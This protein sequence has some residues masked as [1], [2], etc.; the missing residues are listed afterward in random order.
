MKNVIVVSRQ[1]NAVALGEGLK[2]CKSGTGIFMAN[3]EAIKEVLTSIPTEP[4]ETV[5]IYLMDMVQGLQSG[6]AVEYVKTGKTLSGKT[7]TN[8][9]VDAFKE[10]YKLYAERILNVRFG[11]VKYIKKDDV[12]MQNLKKQ[13]YDELSAYEGSAGVSRGTTVVIDPD[14]ELREKLTKLMDKAL[15]EG[16][17]DMYD[18]LEARREKLQQ[19][20]AVTSGVSSVNTPSFENSAESSE[21]VD[22]TDE[23]GNDAPIVF[24][25][26]G[27]ANPEF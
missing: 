10:I 11:L 1:G 9:E 6:A 14:K 27:G 19:P 25:N 5:H 23:S 15:E 18:K 20:K 17:L 22:S 24:E 8:E 16:D 2:I 7:L 21:S 13:A 4:G 3:L 12:A 26:V